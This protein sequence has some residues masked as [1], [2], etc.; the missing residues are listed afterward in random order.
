MSNNQYLA[1]L[2]IM[3]LLPAR[4]KLY[5]FMFPKTIFVNNC[6]GSM[7]KQVNAHKVQKV[8]KSRLL[9]KLLLKCN[10]C[11]TFRSGY[12]LYLFTS[13]YFVFIHLGIFCILSPQYILYLF[14]SV[15]SWRWRQ[16]GKEGCTQAIVLGGLAPGT[17]IMYWIMIMDNDNVV[18]NDNG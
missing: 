6:E 4:S 12:I 2:L 1:E 13:V 14:T 8:I 10:I 3:Q 15:Y 11:F 7:A 17:Q 18:D 9:R 16:V 5:T